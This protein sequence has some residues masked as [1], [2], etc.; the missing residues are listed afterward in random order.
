[1]R[2]RLMW[3]VLVF[4]IMDVQHGQKSYPLRPELIESTYWLYKATRDPRFAGTLLK[5]NFIWLAI[6][7]SNRSCDMVTYLQV[8]WC[9]TRYCKQFAV[10][11]PLHLWILSHIR[12]RVSQAGRSHGE[13]LFSWNGR[14]QIFDSQT[15]H[16]SISIHTF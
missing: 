6:W 12:C 1:M 2:Q 13:L 15:L 10:W 4:K 8:S 11:S 5:F 9:R 16:I 14:E 3:Y 7:E